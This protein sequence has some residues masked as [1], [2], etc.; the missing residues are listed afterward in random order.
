MKSNVLALLAVFTMISLPLAQ[1][2]AAETLTAQSAIENLSLSLSGWNPKA[3]NAQ[4]VRKA[5][6][7]KFLGDIATLQ[8]QGVSNDEIVAAVKAEMPD[9]QTAKD[10]EVLA[11]TAKQ[12]NLSVADTNKLV[13]NYISKAQ[14][15]GAAWSGNATLAVVTGAVIIAVA[16]VLATGGTVTV[17]SGYY[18]D[19]YYYD[20]CGYDYY[21][22]YYCY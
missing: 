12:Q 8:K 21:G 14:T 3:A 5:A 6:V 1:A 16:L 7:N 9:A 20:Y 10:L 19:G 13:M 4:E 15:S 11:K 2:Q 17:S 18:Y 22:Y